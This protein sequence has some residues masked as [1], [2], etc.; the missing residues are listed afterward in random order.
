MPSHGQG[1]REIEDHFDMELEKMEED[2][3]SIFPTPNLVTLFRKKNFLSVV[4]LILL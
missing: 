4:S 3:S 2:K 1:H